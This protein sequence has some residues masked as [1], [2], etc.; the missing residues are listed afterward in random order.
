M[1]VSLPVLTTL[2][3]IP[4][5]D[6]SVQGHFSWEEAWGIWEKRKEKQKKRRASAFPS[7]ILL[8]LEDPLGTLLL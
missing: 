8:P 1:K 7:S 6:Q 4:Q 2:L 5:G 3:I